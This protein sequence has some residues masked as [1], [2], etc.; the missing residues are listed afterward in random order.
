MKKLLFL[1]SFASALVLSSCNNDNTVNP[2]VV[3]GKATIYGTVYA[4]VNN[5][6]SDGPSSKDPVDGA[7]IV[8]R[9]NNAMLVL[10]SS[11]NVNYGY[12]YFQTTSDSNG[13]YTIDIPTNPN[14]GDIKVDI[15]PQDLQ[16]AV[17]QSDGS[18]KP[19]SFF[20][21]NAKVLNFTIHNGSAFLKD[22]AY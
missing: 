19:G 5:K 8:V 16:H 1:L 10:N 6:T 4:E 21:A 2:K 13:K 3:L 7:V 14:I 18:S 11:E 17:I 15:L 22:L 9:I 20:E 12:S